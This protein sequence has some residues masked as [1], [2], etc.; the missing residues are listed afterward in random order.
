MVLGLRRRPV[1]EGSSSSGDGVDKCCKMRRLPCYHVFHRVCVDRWLNLCRKTCPLCRFAI[2]GKGCGEGPLTEER[3][4]WFSS[5]H[6]A[7]F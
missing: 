2:D 7:G 1:I 4:I 3:V 6:A 5:F